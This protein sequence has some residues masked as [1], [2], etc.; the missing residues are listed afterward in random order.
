MLEDIIDYESA[1]SSIASLSKAWCSSLIA[2]R[3]HATRFEDQAWIL[4]DIYTNSK[5]VTFPPAPQSQV[6]LY[7]LPADANVND[8]SDEVAR[9]NDEHIVGIT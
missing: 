1:T 3:A 6:L 4:S 8:C 7:C 9:R 5:T 2:Q